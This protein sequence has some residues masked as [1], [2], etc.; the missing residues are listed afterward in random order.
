MKVA[1]D[2]GSKPALSEGHAVATLTVADLVSVSAI[3]LAQAEGRQVQQLGTR[4]G[5]SPLQIVR[6]TDVMYVPSALE[7]GQSLQVVQQTGMPVEAVFDELTVEFVKRQMLQRAVRVF[8]DFEMSPHNGDVCILGNVFSRN[9]THW[10]EELMKVV[11]LERA[12]IECHYVIAQLPKFARELLLLVGVPADR[13]LEVSTPTIFPSALYT[14]PVSYRNLSE[15]PA[16]LWALREALLEVADDFQP[17]PRLWLERGE[18]TRL[19]R[20]LVNAEEVFRCLDR[21]GFQRIDM[22]TLPLRSQIAAACN[23]QVMSGL[24]GSQFVHSQLMNPGSHIVEC[25]SPLYLNPTYTE[26]YRVLRHKYSQICGTN[27]PVIPYPHGGDVHV[28]CQQLE[29]AMREAS[30]S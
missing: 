29:L 22:G 3:D 6:C 9:F 28:D 24:H 2:F 15:H 10:H 21:Y 12:K 23:M 30:G 7:A 25:F 27:T 26:I 1:A 8:V 5:T 4:N 16:V 19:G 17:G 20:K 13:I 14:T 11:V 18:Q